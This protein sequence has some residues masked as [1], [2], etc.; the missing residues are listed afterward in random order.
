MRAG[1]LSLN[2]PPSSTNIKSALR[3]L[4]SMV[5]LK[6]SVLEPSVSANKDYKNILMLAYYRNGIVHLFLN[7]AYVALAL[8]GHSRVDD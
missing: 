3:H 1:K 2:A 5:S 6:R 7:E 4:G 8:L